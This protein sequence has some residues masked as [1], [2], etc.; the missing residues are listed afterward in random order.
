MWEVVY[1]MKIITWG[2]EV[3]GSEESLLSTN[4]YLMIMEGHSNKVRF[5]QRPE[6]S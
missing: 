6:L 2:S 1:A 4:L 5:E 3:E